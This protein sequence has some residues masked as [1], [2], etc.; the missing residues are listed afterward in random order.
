MESLSVLAEQTGPNP[1]DRGKAGSKYHL[2]VDRTGI[3]LA[4]RLAAANAQDATQLLPLT[5]PI[6]PITGLRGRPGRP[7]LRPNQAPR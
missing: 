5:D 4:V 3:P 6:P 2:V 7:R 1:T